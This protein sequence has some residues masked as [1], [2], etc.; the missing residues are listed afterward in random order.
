MQNIKKCATCNIFTIS[1][2]C[3]A[4]GASTQSTHPP[5]YSRSERKAS[6]RQAEKR[7]L[8]EKKGA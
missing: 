3:P 7:K 6:Y 4:C 1:D 8:R 2:D 5:K